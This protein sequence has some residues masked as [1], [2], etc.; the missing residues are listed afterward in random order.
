MK[1]IAIINKTH[2]TST[3]NWAYLFSTLLKISFAFKCLW[4]IKNGLIEHLPPEYKSSDESL[5]EKCAFGFLKHHL[6]TLDEFWNIAY[7]VFI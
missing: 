4:K 7:V 3:G 5:I 1:T 2:I 6:K